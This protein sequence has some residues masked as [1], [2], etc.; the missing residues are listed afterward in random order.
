MPKI[1]MKAARINANL[2]RR[3]IADKMGVTERTIQ[4]WEN[5]ER[6]PKFSSLKMFAEI[7]GFEAE[8]IY[9]PTNLCLRENA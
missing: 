2:S 8:D 9:L 7:C 6:Y 1:I 3:E 5:G 4:S